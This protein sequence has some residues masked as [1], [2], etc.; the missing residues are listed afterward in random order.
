MRSFAAVEAFTVK[1]IVGLGNP[2]RQ[3]EHTR[4][5]AGFWVVDEL[6]RRWNINLNSKK[7][8]SI[9][10]EGHY[11]GEKVVLVKPQTYMN[12]SGL[13]VQEIVRYW[14]VD[15]ADLLVIYDDLD[16]DPYRIRLRSKGSSGGHRGVAS[17]IDLLQTDEFPRLKIGIGRPQ[18]SM[19]VPDYV[20]AQLSP[21]ELAAYQDAVQ[22]C[23]DAVEAWISLGIEQAMNQYNSTKK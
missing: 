13:A 14:P 10:A 20:L 6:A 3:Y 8:R 23:A 2:G 4:H 9:V 1:V 11:A 12:L 21:E 17:I 19:S 15:F 22:Q 7:F 18:G 5:N 16:M